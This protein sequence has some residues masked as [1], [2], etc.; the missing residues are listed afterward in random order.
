MLADLPRT[1]RMD[2]TLAAENAPSPRPTGLIANLASAGRSLRYEG[3]RATAGKLARRIG[4]QI[5]GG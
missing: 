1:G 3:F 2:P 5:S 4:D